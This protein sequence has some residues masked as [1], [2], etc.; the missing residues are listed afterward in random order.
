[1][2]LWLEH[3][4]SASECS[5][6]PSNRSPSDEI[7]Q[8]Y[9]TPSTAHFNS[10]NPRSHHAG[11]STIV[12]LYRPCRFHSH[13]GPDPGSFDNR[14]PQVPC[15]SAAPGSTLPSTSGLRFRLSSRLSRECHEFPQH[16]CIGVFGFDWRSVF[17]EREEGGRFDLCGERFSRQ[18]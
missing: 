14:S 4:I 7:L 10:H 13:R 8:S 12:R 1:M 9:L 11:N 16:I 15:L 5:R 18:V 2:Q 3:G 6:K 17:P